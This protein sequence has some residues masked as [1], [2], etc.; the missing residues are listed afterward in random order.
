M[1][2]SMRKFMSRILRILV[3]NIRI[4][5]I[6]VIESGRK[7]KYSVHYRFSRT[8]TKLGARHSLFRDCVQ[9]RKR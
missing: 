3:L 5:R 9:F 7:R 8:M 2:G 4:L 6:I 1:F